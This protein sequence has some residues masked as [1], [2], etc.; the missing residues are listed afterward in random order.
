MRRTLA[1]LALACAMLAPASAADLRVESPSVRTGDTWMYNKLSG[2]TGALEDVSVN[3]VT[4]L[5]REGIAMQSAS[6]D[7]SA[8]AQ[9]QR[10]SSFNLVRIDGPGF[11]QT[12]APFYPNYSFPLY[13]GKSWAGKVVL[14]NSRQGDTE[15][16]A[17]LAGRAVRWEMVTVP[18]GNFLAL[19]LEMKG[20]YTSRSMHGTVSGTIEDTLWYS[21]E[22]RNAVRYEYKDFVGGSRYNHEIHELARFWPGP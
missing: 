12:A 10:T 3:S 9:I 2:W 6:L 13:A 17:A 20:T 18:A 15:V 4:R 5:D 1:L 8:T 19:R 11:R 7:G 22:V 14:N 16:V 21:P